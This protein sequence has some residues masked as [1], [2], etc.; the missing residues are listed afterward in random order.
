MVSRTAGLVLAVLVA[1]NPLLVWY[2]Q[3][4]RPYS[5]LVLLCALS[6]LLFARRQPWAW[7]A[8]SALA[9]LTH[10]FAAFLVVPEG[11][12]LVWVCRPRA[13]AL[14]AAAVVAVV[15]AALI[16]LAAHEKSRIGTAYF[17]GMSLRRRAIG[18][19]EDYLVGLVVKFDAT[20]EQLLEALALALAAVGVV[21]A[22]LHAR[23]PAVVAGALVLAVAGIPLVVALL[24]Q[25]FLN[26]RN[27]IAGCVPALLVVAAG[28]AAPAAPRAVAVAGVG[29]LCLAGVATTVVT[30]ADPQYR[31]SDFRGSAEA[32]GPVRGARAVVVPGVVGDVA[33]PLYLPGLARMPPG[34]ARVVEVDYVTPRS[35]RLGGAAVAR[36]RV[37]PS[38][39]PPFRLV[40]RRYEETFT[41][42]RYT[43]PAL[44]A[45]TPAELGRA[46]TRVVGLP[47]VLVQRP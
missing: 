35:S 40:E 13:R 2:S 30:A 46:G 20:W 15:G 10:Y 39:P 26:T 37:P 9:L 34:G 47:S 42:L 1:F 7:A 32:L 16:P 6:V 28:F 17:E 14:A 36:L 27:V 3:E 18:V 8:A 29:L 31:R 44:T 38:L 11:L 25:D 23:R 33:M 12:W 43:A 5:L 24:G 21:L 4:A 45:V 41:L 22:W 19:P